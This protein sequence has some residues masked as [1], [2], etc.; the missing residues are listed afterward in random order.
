MQCKCK[1]RVG[2]KGADRERE[3][4]LFDKLLLLLKKKD[5]KR[6]NYKGHIEV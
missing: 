3:L 6:Y 1:V 4:I 5:A 2:K